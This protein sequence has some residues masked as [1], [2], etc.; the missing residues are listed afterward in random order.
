MRRGFTY[1]HCPIVYI[2]EID[3]S[4]ARRVLSYAQ[5]GEVELAYGRRRY[6]A[7]YSRT[8]RTGAA[9]ERVYSRS[10]NAAGDRGANGSTRNSNGSNASE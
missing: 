9:G 4:S 10:R 8:K 6:S 1:P 5:F 7:T 3:L 2:R